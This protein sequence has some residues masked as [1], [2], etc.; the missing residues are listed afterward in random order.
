MYSTTFVRSRAHNAGPIWFRQLTSYMFCPF[1]FRYLVCSTRNKY[2]FIFFSLLFVLFRSE[3]SN[4]FVY[5]FQFVKVLYYMMCT[6]YID[7]KQK[8]IRVSI[9]FVFQSLF[10]VFIH[11]FIVRIRFFV[12]PQFHWMRW[13]VSGRRKKRA[14][15][16][17]EIDLKRICLWLRGTRFPSP[18]RWEDVKNAHRN[19]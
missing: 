8:T 10:R 18:L 17:G 3:T 6:V 19:I 14:W 5:I 12:C 2:G 15:A 4:M 11:L 16:T 13:N 1:L 7:T 9:L